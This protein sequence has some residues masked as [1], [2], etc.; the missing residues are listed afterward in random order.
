MFCLEVEEEEKEPNEEGKLP[1][2][3]YGV[4]TGTLLVYPLFTK[5]LFDSSA[6]HS[7]IK[8]IT[9][10]RFVC[11]PDDRDVQLCVTTHLGSLYHTDIVF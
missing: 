5:I 4:V 6:T 8:L 9:A 7:F 2:D 10:K 1:K 3:P 11:K